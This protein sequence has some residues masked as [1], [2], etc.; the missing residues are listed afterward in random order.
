MIRP[1]HSPRLLCFLAGFTAMIILLD[2][3]RTAGMSKIR[4]KKG[5]AF[6]F[7]DLGTK[8]VNPFE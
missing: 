2:L 7:K 4:R 8:E 3:I 1:G 5:S 6:Y